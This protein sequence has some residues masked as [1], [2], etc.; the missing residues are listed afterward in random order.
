MTKEQVVLI[1]DKNH[2][3]SL[4]MTKRLNSLGLRADTVSTAQG[5]LDYLHSSDH[6]P[7]LI[8]VNLNEDDETLVNLP[9][10]VQN[11]TQWEKMIPFAA[12][13]AIVDKTLMARLIRAGYSDLLI[14]PVEHEMFKDRIEKLLKKNVSLSTQTFK[15]PLVEN[16]FLQVQICLREINEFGLMAHTSMPLAVD[17]QLSL[18]SPSISDILNGPVAVRVV[19]CTAHGRGDFE[20]VFSFVG[21]AAGDLRAF[22]K[23][24]MILAKPKSA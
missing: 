8:L 4:I 23:F 20:V 17:S 22:R 1:V 10:E 15:K 2:S 16:G 12:L 6:V 11:N 14:R 3:S 9:S 19:S 5:A 13:S 24:A 21:L 18:Q 7:D